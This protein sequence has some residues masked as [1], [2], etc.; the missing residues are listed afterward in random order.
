MGQDPW[1]F[2][3]DQWV[4]MLVMDSARAAIW[5][6]VGCGVLTVYGLALAGAYALL[7]RK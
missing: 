1:T 7:R 5:V 3:A 6:V 2:M 4:R